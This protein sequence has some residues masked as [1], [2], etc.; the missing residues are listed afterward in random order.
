MKKEKTGAQCSRSKA[1]AQ[2]A[3][4]D[5][6]EAVLHNRRPEPPLSR[7]DNLTFDA[8]SL[9][10][11]ALCFLLGGLSKGLVGMGLQTICIG[12]LVV[13]FDKTLAME[14]L[15]VPALITNIWQI[16]GMPFA[17]LGRRLLPLLIFAAAGIWI[18]S[19]ALVL[20]DGR[21]LSIL[22][23]ILLLIYTVISLTGFNISIPRQK[24]GPLGFAFGGLNGLFTGMTGSYL[25]PAL[26][27]LHGMGLFF[28]TLSV[29]LGFALGR[30]DLLS[31]DIALVSTVACLPALLGMRVGEK[32]RGTLSDKTFRLLF[33]LAVAGVAIVILLRSVLSI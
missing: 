28:V 14:L 17:T 8:F 6:T 4:V 12:L 25:F 11:I 20:V 9:T 3:R 1:A 22:L 5:I 30:H 31:T 24:E 7:S 33:F 27:Y 19:Y 23:A 21:L 32:L 26:V 18:G 2:S 15:L 13:L 16:R 10:Y 29:A